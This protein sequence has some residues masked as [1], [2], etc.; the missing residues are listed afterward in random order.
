MKSAGGPGKDNAELQCEVE[1]LNAKLRA[2]KA[3]LAKMKTKYQTCQ[4]NW[5]LWKKTL[6][7]TWTNLSL[8]NRKLQKKLHEASKDLVKE[9]AERLNERE[10]AMEQ[11]THLVNL[12]LE[13]KNEVA[14]KELR[15]LRSRTKKKRAEAYMERH[16]Y[17]VKCELAEDQVALTSGEDVSVENADTRGYWKKVVW[18]VQKESVKAF[19]MKRW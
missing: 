13:L 6:F 8:E 15:K 11:I 18:D 19:G 9:R 1:M 5:M 17:G 4:K 14:R 16:S 10:A 2:E 7:R 3:S 12:Y